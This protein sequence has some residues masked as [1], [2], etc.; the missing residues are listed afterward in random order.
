MA[1]GIQKYTVV[2]ASNLALGQAGLDVLATDAN[3]AGTWVAIKA[4]GADIPIDAI[5]VSNGDPISSTFTLSQGDI[6]YGTFTNIEVGTVPAAA[7]CLA[8]RG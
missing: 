4:V 2:E 6:I 7:R 3:E 5:S 1:S 8:Y